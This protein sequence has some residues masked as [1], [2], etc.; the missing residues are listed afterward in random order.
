MAY[1]LKSDNKLSEKN[2]ASRL[3]TISALMAN[4]RVFLQKIKDNSYTVA[5]LFFR[6]GC[7]DCDQAL[8]IHYRELYR[9]GKKVTTSSTNLLNKVERSFLKRKKS[10]LQAYETTWFW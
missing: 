4:V 6:C 5:V 3:S 8:K 9:T 10:G 2:S 7:L 1:V